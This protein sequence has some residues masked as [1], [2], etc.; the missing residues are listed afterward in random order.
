MPTTK[1]DQYHSASLE[2]VELDETK[3]DKYKSF[4]ISN[5]RLEKFKGR[6]HVGRCAPSKF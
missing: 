3:F 2:Q 6:Q 5:G 4:K 1:A